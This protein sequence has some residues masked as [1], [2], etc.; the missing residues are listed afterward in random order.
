MEK[1][2]HPP[3]LYTK[4]QI[5]VLTFLRVLIG[6]HFLYEG[7]VKLYAPGEWTSEFFLLNSVGPFS[8]VLKSMAANHT[9]LYWVDQANMWGLIII[10][11]CLFVGVFARPAKIMGILL[12]FL[13]YISYPPFAL[14]SVSIPVE[15]SY[16]IVNKNLIELAALVVL[17]FFPSSRITGLDRYMN[18]LKITRPSLDEK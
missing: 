13:Y 10:G 8:S 14:Y 9:V 17:Y 6:W 3:L 4:R 2:Q 7:L 18:F 15:G 16:W 1:D 12:L 11:I 5:A